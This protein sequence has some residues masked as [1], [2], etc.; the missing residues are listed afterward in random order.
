MR[1]RNIVL[2]VRQAG[3]GVRLL[4]IYQEAGAPVHDV[5]GC[6]AEGVVRCPN[7]HQAAIMLI[8]SRHSCALLTRR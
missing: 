4:S 1:R 8:S 6:L 3:A 2:R 5:G 7:R